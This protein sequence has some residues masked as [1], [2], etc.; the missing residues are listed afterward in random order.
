MLTNSPLC[1]YGL[2]GALNIAYGWFVCAVRIT[3][4]HSLLWVTTSL[5]IT[6]PYKGR[7]LVGVLHFAHTLIFRKLKDTV[8]CSHSVKQFSG[9]TWTWCCIC[10]SYIYD[11]RLVARAYCVHGYGSCCVYI[12]MFIYIMT[13]AHTHHLGQPDVVCCGCAMKITTVWPIKKNSF[14]AYR[15][16]GSHHQQKQ[17]AFSGT[18][19]P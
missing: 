19:T 3:A 9:S 2:P 12:Y 1:L 11:R 18:I 8:E 10:W 13:H 14:P 5:G 6:S 15:H 17:P 4:R 16:F 7:W